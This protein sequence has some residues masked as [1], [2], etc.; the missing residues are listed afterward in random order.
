MITEAPT[1]VPMVR[2][3]RWFMLLLSVS[4]L[5]CTEEIIIS[6]QD[7]LVDPRF[8]PRMLF[9]F[10]PAN[11][12]GPYASWGEFPSLDYSIIM[13]FNKLMDPLSVKAGLRLR[14]S[15]RSITFEPSYPAP[16]EMTEK[17]TF[18]L[19][20]SG[21]YGFT[22]P[23]IGEILT[24]SVER[25]ILDING[26]AMPPGVI[27]P[28]LP[29]PAFRVRGV[30]PAETEIAEVYG[31][32]YLKFNSSVDASIIS[33]ISVEPP[34][35][36]P[37]GIISYDSSIVSWP[38]A[39]LQGGLYTIT[40]AGGARDKWGNVTTSAFSSTVRV[41]G[42]AIT[43]T[44][45]PNGATHVPL[46]GS[47]AFT[48]SSPLD[49]STISRAFHLAPEVEGGLRV[50]PSYYGFSVSPRISFAPS[51]SYTISVDTSLHS[52]FGTRLT[53]PI[54]LAFTT[55]PFEAQYSYP[56]NYQLNVPLSKDI[57]I[58][59]SARLD[60][61]TIRGAFSI[62]PPTEGIA[63]S[64]NVERTKLFFALF[65]NLLPSTTYT[66]RI[67][68]TLASRGGYRLEEPFA[69]TFTTAGP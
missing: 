46:D 67:D 12:V 16:R 10:P 63:Y 49:T 19:R 5:S 7:A 69:L 56:A 24:L 41:R 4:M 3:C 9:S 48:F 39:G 51:T 35:T 59:F 61:S 28:M 42:L 32:I 44:P 37:W 13:R 2:M 50:N 45:F 14:S 43:G 15:L 20:D 54:S 11:T 27:G 33:S 30:L 68:T 8:A 38:A 25:P 65:E 66:V 21:A 6:S 31:T 36:T 58:R 34:F 47:L 29:E 55:S 26:N 18:V 22:P 1:E 64:L 53:E 40:V 60:T 62:F 17:F 23:R 57:Y 52:V